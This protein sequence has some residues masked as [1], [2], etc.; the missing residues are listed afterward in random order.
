M[1]N[2][3][4]LRI[5]LNIFMFLVLLLF[6]GDTRQ[7][8]NNTKIS[9]GNHKA[10]DFN[11]TSE[12]TTEHIKATQSTF[13]VASEHNTTGK[14]DVTD[15]WNAT[16]LSIRNDMKSRLNVTTGHDYEY[17]SQS[18]LNVTTEH[19]NEETSQSILNMTTEHNNEETSQSILSVTTEH[20]NDKTSTPSYARPCEN[21]ETLQTALDEV[22]DCTTY[23]PQLY[24][25]HGNCGNKTSPDRH[26][27]CDVYCLVNNDCCSDF[28]QICPVMAEHSHRIMESVQDQQIQW[29]CTKMK[30][31]V[32]VKMITTCP[33]SSN[34]QCNPHGLDLLEGY[35]PVFDNNTGLYYLNDYCAKCNNFTNGEL[36]MPTEFTCPFPLNFNN[37]EKLQQALYTKTC[38]LVFDQM[39]HQCWMYESTC[40][41]D[42]EFNETVQT[43]CETNPVQMY[44]T[45]YIY[46]NEYCAICAND[47]PGDVFA[48]KHCSSKTNGHYNPILERFSFSL[49]MNIN[50][51]RELLVEFNINGKRRSF[52]CE[53][54]SNCNDAC[55]AGYELQ[56]DTCVLMYD[57]KPV[58][59]TFEYSIPGEVYSVMDISSEFVSDLSFVFDRLDVSKTLNKR[60]VDK[61]S[62]SFSKDYDTDSKRLKG[63]FVAK[64]NV[65][66]P[67]SRNLTMH[68]FHNDTVD[69]MMNFM[70]D[71]FFSTSDEDSDFDTL[72]ICID[73]VNLV[74]CYDWL[75]GTFLNQTD[76]RVKKVGLQSMEIMG[77]VTI[78]CLTLSIICMLLR[79]ISQAFVSIFHS[80][81]GK[82]Q[83][84]FV[85][86][87]CVS[88]ILY[89]IGPFVTD[90]PSLCEAIGILIHFFFLVSFTWMGIIALEMYLTFRSTLHNSKGWK[91]ILLYV[92][93]SMFLPVIVISVA[94]T[95]DHVSV[96]T[97]FKPFYGNSVTGIPNSDFDTTNSVPSTSK[98]ENGENLNSE[99]Q[100]CQMSNPYATLL[101]F[102]CPLGVMIVFNTIMY[103]LTVS[104]LKSAWRQTAMVS[105]RNNFHFDVYIKLFIIMGFTW[106][107][108]FIAPFVH[109]AI[110][111]VFIVLNASQG[112]FIFI[113]SVCTK[114]VLNEI[115]SKCMRGNKSG[116]SSLN[117]SAGTNVLNGKTGQL[118]EDPV[119]DS[120][121]L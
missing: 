78:I 77:L 107:F 66:L 51:D 36:Q 90:I 27:A 102:A 108:G 97:R 7:V 68:Q 44:A 65:K 54:L 23:M 18:I 71:E 61:I 2:I 101:F 15:S 81:A 63:L 28:T 86:S 69:A 48:N 113:S 53:N 14:I 111:Y 4:Q 25:C 67:I 30:H 100:T 92:F 115:K 41:P 114:V 80:F 119:M 57:I 40:H 59:A 6:C 32:P 109:E 118:K 93:I 112:V 94:V 82:I 29:D 12:I 55:I 26:C 5:S 117:C 99:V 1:K 43:L 45:N 39:G 84:C 10:T 49:V 9:K 60:F 64:I 72:T 104:S 52:R 83:F 24:S 95:L 42:C 8:G 16:D 3:V 87:L 106:I 89:L 98:L 79:L 73:V 50:P 96:D 31:N 19:N 47:W 22:K 103:I 120:T 38:T 46:K 74:T 17:T 20:N 37:M 56:N 11:I 85:S 58:T 88:N 62:Y 70:K 34:K 91:R 76:N 35:M 75:N 33:D 13:D 121:S 110:V 116:Q 21:Q 105:N